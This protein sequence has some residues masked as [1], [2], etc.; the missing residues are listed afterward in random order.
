MSKI[1]LISSKNFPFKEDKE[2]CCT[3]YESEFYKIKHIEFLNSDE[4][5]RIEVTVK[6]NGAI[7]VPRIFVE[8][9]VDI[10]NVSLMAIKIHTSSDSLTAKEIEN[11]IEGYKIAIKTVEWIE[12]H[13]PHLLVK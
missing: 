9:F 8:E 4:T 11:V 10:E 13:F 5:G 6:E 12:E 7:P 3:I 2:V 1:N